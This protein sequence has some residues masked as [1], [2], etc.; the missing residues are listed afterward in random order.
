MNTINTG[1]EKDRTNATITGIFYLAATVTSV[2][3]LKLYEPILYHPNYLIHGTENKNQIILGAFLELCTVGTVTGTAVMLYPYLRKFNENLG[4]GYL[5]FRMLE[6][7]LI[8]VGIVSVL[9]LLTLGLT[10]TN[11][12]APDVAA[13]QTNGSV[14]KAIHDWTFLLGPN[15]MLGINTFLYSLIFYRSQLIPRR[16]SLLGLAGAI[17][18]F[19]AALLEMFGIIIQISV[20][21]LLFALPIFAYELIL[22]I[23]LIFKGFNPEVLASIKHK[24]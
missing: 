23:W 2:V 8:L 21:G 14:L 16:L 19:T 15:F 6:A 11:A 18:I 24:A 4:L 3:A 13:Y 7:I 12:V 5:C 10:F 20:W 9:S 17:F 1:K 22:A